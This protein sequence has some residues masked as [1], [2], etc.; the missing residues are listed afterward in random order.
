MGETHTHL[1][2][3]TRP[4]CL[5]RPGKYRK[6]CS[7]LLSDTGVGVVF[8]CLPPLKGGYALYIHTRL[9]I[10]LRG[11]AYTVYHEQTRT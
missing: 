8:F 6:H 9:H 7:G 2:G 3:M 11:D 5:Q 4:T 1:R 10:K